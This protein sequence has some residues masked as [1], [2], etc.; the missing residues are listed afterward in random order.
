[1]FHSKRGVNI[2]NF[3]MLVFITLIISAQSF[4]LGT[5]LVVKNIDSHS[6]I[7]LGED[8]RPNEDGR[9]LAEQFYEQMRKREEKISR[10]DSPPDDNETYDVGSRNRLGARRKFT[11]RAG[12]RDSTGTPSAGLFSSQSGSIFAI[13]AGKRSAFTRKDSNRIRNPK[14]AMLRDEINFMSVS[15]NETTIIIQGFLVLLLLGFTVY[16]GLSGGITDGTDR[17]GSVPNEFNGLGVESFD[18]SN[19]RMDS[20]SIV[21]SVAAD[22]SKG[23]TSIFI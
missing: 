9:D 3:S 13:D 8:D 15:S 20:P 5:S 10:N 19:L 1:M 16:V 2:I 21:D 22:G 7:F 11:G 4:I 14:D 18:F 23:A 12:E 6:R 17:F